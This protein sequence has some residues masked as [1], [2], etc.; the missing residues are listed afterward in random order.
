MTDE[1]DIKKMKVTELRDALTKRGL[2]TEGLK[3]ELINRLQARLDEEEF[4]IA[5]APPPAA[6]GSP[7]AAPEAGKMDASTAVVVEEKPAEEPAA[8]SSDPAKEEAPPAAAP[9]VEEKET[10]EE[11][12][13]G[14]EKGGESKSKEE[15][16]AEKVTAVP[17]ATAGMSFK[18]RMEQ[19][20]KRFG[21][22]P[23]E[24]TKKDM[25]AQR[26]GTG[27]NKAGAGGA[28]KNGPKQQQGGNRGKGGQNKTPA[29]NGPKNQQQ[30]G[31]KKREGGAGGGGG[32]G[33]KQKVG[34]KPLLPKDEIE[35]RLARA[36]KYGTTEGVDELKAMLRRHRFST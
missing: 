29:K 28:N 21:I 19:R 1:T 16:V 10:A 33:K 26:F 15:T 32:S 5:Q 20:A 8:A 23:S 31:N 36:A 6:A 35:K 13:D 2:S 25:R 27:G 24:S 18:E 3:A 11:K 34:E 14:A 22:K 30:A 9:P 12:K 4:G 17:K 7:E